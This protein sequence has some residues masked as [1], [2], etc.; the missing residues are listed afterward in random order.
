MKQPPG[1]QIGWQVLTRNLDQLSTIT[2]DKG[3]D[4]DDLREELRAH[5]IESEF[6]YKENGNHDK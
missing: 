4:W 1:S 5:G 2:T 3:F 6:K